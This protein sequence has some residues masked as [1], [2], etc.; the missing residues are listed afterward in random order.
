MLQAHFARVSTHEGAFLCSLNLL[1]ELAP[2][3]LT[4]YI[5]WSIL[6]GGNSE[7]LLPRM[8]YTHEIVLH[9]EELSSRSK[10]PRVYRPLLMSAIGNLQLAIRVV[11]NRRAGKQKS[12]WDKANKRHLGLLVEVFHMNSNQAAHETRHI[13]PADQPAQL[14]GS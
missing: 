4:G 13:H 3:Y 2:K 6:W 1:R 5:S 10:I 11:Q 12:H 14:P 8:K 9:T 7:I